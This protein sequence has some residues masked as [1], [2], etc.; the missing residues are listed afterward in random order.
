MIVF[1]AFLID[2]C[3]SSWLYNLDK[4]YQRYTDVGEQLQPQMYIF[5]QRTVDA[6]ADNNAY[7]FLSPVYYLNSFSTQKLCVNIG[8]SSALFICLCEPW[9]MTGE[10]SPGAAFDGLYKFYFVCGK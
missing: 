8:K 6:R 7:P 9:T 3:T 1:F 2:F 4:I 5:M 10:G